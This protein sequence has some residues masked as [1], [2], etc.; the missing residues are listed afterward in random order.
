MKVSSYRR[1]ASDEWE[2]IENLRPATPSLISHAKSLS[3]LEADAIKLL[4]RVEASIQQARA[5]AKTSKIPVEIEEILEFKSQSLD[6]TAKHMQAL[7]SAE[8]PDVEPLSRSQRGIANGLVA[9]LELNSVRLR[10]EGKRL[11][12]SL[13]TD[14]PPTAANIDY[15][16][17][18]DQ[19]EIVRLG[20]RRPLSGPHKD[21]MQEYEVR[22]R[23]GKALW[24][25]HFHY[26]SPQAAPTAFTAAHLKTEAQRFMSARA[27][28]AQA[29]STTAV[30][31]IYRSKITLAL[32]EKLFLAV[33]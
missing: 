2:Q 31:Q 27:L 18:Q 24:Y 29:G 7:L 8:G 13:I 9:Q 30:I 17:A 10:A 14:L 20:K 22:S 4:G 16:K 23:D 32:A 12:I 11:R 33:Q 3:R 19:V 21:Y 25:A 6:E 5:F 26:D 28:Y 15:L 1:G